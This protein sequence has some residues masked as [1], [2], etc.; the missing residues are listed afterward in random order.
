VHVADLAEVFRRVLEDD[1]A[2]GYYVIGN[3][4]NPTVTELTDA[5][6]VAAGA[7]GAVPG[8]DDEARARLGDYFAEVLLLD[9]ANAA[10]RARSELG[11]SP[12]RPT[13]VEEFRDG[14]YRR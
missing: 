11:W 12:S 8:S 6:A 14:S 10:T 4:Q 13:L 7:P 2:S 1:T 3:S 5:A 9:Q